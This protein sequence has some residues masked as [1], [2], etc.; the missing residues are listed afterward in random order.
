MPAQ[1]KRPGI[2]FQY[3][4]NWTLDEEEAAGGE[5]VTVYSPGGAFWTVSL[6]PPNTNPSELARAALQ[7]MRQ[8][9]EQ[10]DAEDARETI[11]GRELVG[12]DLNFYYLDLISTARIRCLA[13][14]ENTY[15]V[16]CQGEDREFDQV[17]PVFQ[18]MT[19]SLLSSLGSENATA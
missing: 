10:L 19:T 2:E 9:Y 4:E 14:D 18:A 13:A 3:P 15:A 12:F 17:Q 5:S 11:G 16:F 8:E 7:A 1:F 6:H